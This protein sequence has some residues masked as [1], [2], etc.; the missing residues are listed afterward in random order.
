MVCKNGT[1]IKCTNIF[2]NIY[3]VDV[4]VGNLASREL[5]ETQ[6]KKN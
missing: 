2:F 6:S 5:E 1:G 3:F 4:S